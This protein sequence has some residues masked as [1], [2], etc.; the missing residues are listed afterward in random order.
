MRTRRLAAVVLPLV[1]LGAL[2]ACAQSPD[3]AAPSSSAP[4]S[5]DPTATATTE[6]TPTATATPPADP[7]GFAVPGACE[8]VWTPEK[9]QELSA[10]TVLNDPGVTMLSTEVVEGL[11]V[12]D[13]VPHL[14]C[15]WGEPSEWGIATTVAAVDATQ[16]ATIVDALSREGFVCTEAT[17]QRCER[18]QTTPSD[19]SGAPDVTLGET[20]LIGEGGWV[21]THWLNAE[22]EPGYSD[23]IAAQLWG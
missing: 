3:G 21:A 9:F 8:D 15:T 22:V 11:E 12:L 18:S 23:S 19:T 17:V 14:R 10:S 20:H 16:T 13:V 1:M 2:A 7:V 5:S 4:T 6:P